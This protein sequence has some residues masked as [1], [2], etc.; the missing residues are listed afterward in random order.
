MKTLPTIYHDGSA[1]REQRSD[2]SLVSRRYF[3]SASTLSFVGALLAGAC[4]GG[5][6]GGPT[7]VNPP[8]G[9]NTTGITVSGNVITIDLT[10][11]TSLASANGY[12]IVGRPAAIVINTGNDAFR[13]FTSTCTHEGCTVSDF[14]GGRIH[15]PCHGSQFDSS[16]QAV[17]GPATRA[18]KE[19]AVALDPS[20]R[21]L[22]VTTS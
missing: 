18:L 11:V 14:S 13:A 1:E 16:G 7:G 15:C 4:S 10:R 12:V 8:P 5:D 21:I 20:S 6:D 17:V 2:P 19:F 22:T 9:G 3:V